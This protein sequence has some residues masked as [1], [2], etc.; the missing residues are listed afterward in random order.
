MQCIEAHD[1]PV[2]DMDFEPLTSRLASCGSPSPA[3]FRLD[4]SL[5]RLNSKQTASTRL[6][7]HQRNIFFVREGEQ[8][9]V[10][11]LES[12]EV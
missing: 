5:G 9:V 4:K 6:F 12:H 11:L 7:F 10:L 3:I 1:G 2:E 8:L